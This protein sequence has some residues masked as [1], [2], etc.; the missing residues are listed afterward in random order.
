MLKKLLFIALTL[1]AAQASWG[2]NQNQKLLRFEEMGTELTDVYLS[3]DNSA[4]VQVVCHKDIPLTFSTQLDDV[5]SLLET[6]DLGN[7]VL[8]KMVFPAGDKVYKDRILTIMS[9]AGNTIL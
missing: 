3:E 5:E 2:Q 8:Y 7:E 4:M 9:P 1:L 6:E